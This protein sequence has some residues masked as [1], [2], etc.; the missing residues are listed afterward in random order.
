MVRD[1]IPVYQ[2]KLQ[3]RDLRWEHRP[4]RLHHYW[5]RSLAR[6]TDR[7]FAKTAITFEDPLARYQY[8]YQLDPR[9]QKEFL[10]FS[11]RK[12]IPAIRPVGKALLI[13][14]AQAAPSFSPA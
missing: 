11:V 9:F 4:I 14:S 12:L 2:K 6:C 7:D 3:S 10:R 8:G 5:S 13:V 1:Q